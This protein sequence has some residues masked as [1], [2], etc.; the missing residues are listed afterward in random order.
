MVMQRV[1]D[2]LRNRKK[3]STAK[4]YEETDTDKDKWN[5]ISSHVWK[6]FEPGG[7][8]SL[9]RIYEGYTGHVDHRGKSR[10]T[11]DEI[12]A[13]FTGTRTSKIVGDEA[14]SFK[15]GEYNNSITSLNKSFNRSVRSQET[16]QEASAFKEDW[17]RFKAGHKLVF[18]QIVKDVQGA[19][20][21]GTPESKIRE[22][23]K[24]NRVRSSDIS[25]ILNNKYKEPT[26]SS[27]GKNKLR[28][29]EK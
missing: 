16:G 2:I 18:Q 3:D 14:L 9:R 25:A 10:D 26:M 22:A 21:L 5:K 17:E 27:A 11:G 15:A 7:M 1:L 28:A 13:A 24:S 8:T 19:R 29:L 12:I 20:A 6:A 4:V 23:L